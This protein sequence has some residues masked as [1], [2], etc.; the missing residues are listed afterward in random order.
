MPSWLHGLWSGG[1]LQAELVKLYMESL[2]PCPDLGKASTEKT[3][4]SE[5]LVTELTHRA[6]KVK[7]I[8]EKE[9]KEAE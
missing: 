1:W 2:F 9:K 6:W 3:L 4:A 5:E 8:G 7:G